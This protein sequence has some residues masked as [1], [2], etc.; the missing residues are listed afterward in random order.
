M[1]Y[2]NIVLMILM[3]TLTTLSFSESDSK[4]K[5]E[6]NKKVTGSSSVAEDKKEPWTAALEA[7]SLNMSIWAFN[8]HIAKSDFAYINWDT[9]SAN[10]N[11]GFVWDVDH[12]T[13]NFF[14]H[15][16]HGNLYFNCAR[17]N[18][19]SFWESIPY[20]IGGSL[21]WEMAME[22]NY[23]SYNDLIM[24]ATGGI[25]LGETLYRFSSLVLD[26]TAVGFNRVWREIVGG[27]I[28]PVRGF[29]RLINGKT[30]RVS[31]Y[32][33]QIR[34]PV[35]GIFSIGSHDKLKSSEPEGAKLQPLL[36]ILLIYG[37]FH[38][39]EKTFKPFDFFVFRGWVTN[40]ENEFLYN[41]SEYGLLAGKSVKVG[42]SNH[43]YGVFQYF[44]FLYNEITEISSSAVGAGSVSTFKLN[45]KLSLGTSAH[46]G[47]IM[48]GASNNEYF[49]EEDRDYNY[50]SGFTLKLDTAL[51]HK[52]LGMMIFAFSHYR[53]YTINGA[54]GNE[55][56][57]LLN[58]K[59]SIPVWKNWNL[60]LDYSTYF[61]DSHYKDFPDVRKNYHGL[62]IFF[63]YN[64]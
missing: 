6:K 49:L 44:D 40:G 27:L 45:E 59:Y 2:I 33:N 10:F 32:H 51:T 25:L 52:S 12:F 57:Y 9:I 28:N 30:T 16:Y 58:V 22:N 36:S 34:K 39:E 19:L 3:L 5:Q 31:S 24:T 18:G 17:S 41:I 4:Q 54:L 61:R 26:D 43:L 53:I 38:D 7:F 46:L 1:K 60:G 47:F 37:S 42:N 56:L 13:M 63:S 21:M 14:F 11:N 35:H 23:P 64:F 50:G 15:P 62:R 48:M 20:T 8:R 29:N 55:S